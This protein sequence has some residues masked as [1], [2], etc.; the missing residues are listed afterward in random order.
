MKLSPEILLQGYFLLPLGTAALLLLVP[1]RREALISGFAFWSMALHLAAALG[2]IGWWLWH[3]MPTYNLAEVVI[4]AK[5]GYEFLIDLHFD[6]ITAVFLVVG[7]LLTFL[8]GTYSRYYMHREAG[9]RRFFSTILFFFSGYCIVIFSGN[10]ETL[11]IGWEVLGVASFLLIAFYRHRYL[12][13][14]HAVKIFSIYRVGD[15]GLIL[16][17]WATHHLFHG[18]LTFVQLPAA[19]TRTPEL[20]APSGLGLAI[21]LMFLVTAAGKSAQLPFSSWLPRAMEG[22]TPSSAIFYGSLSVHMGV[23]LLLRTYPYWESQ[24]WVRV[25]M[26]VLGLATAFI[27]T[28]IGRV[29]AAAKAQI[30]YASIAQIGVMFIEVAFGWHGLALLHFAG[31]AF[32]RTYQLLISPSVVA[33]LL[34]EQFYHY[35]RVPKIIERHYPRRLAMTLYILCV[36]EWNLDELLYHYVWSPL[37]WIGGLLAFLSPRR[38]LVL[39]GPL[40]V[41]GLGLLFIQGRLPQGAMAALPIACAAIGLALVLKS[42]TKRVHTRVAFL[43]VVVNHLWVGLA[44]SFN[45]QFATPELLYYL[46]GALGAGVIGLAALTWLKRAEPGVSLG[47]F[48]GHIHGHPALGLVFF[49]ACLG[50][51]GFPISTTFIGEDLVFSHIHADQVLLSTLVALSYLVD[52]L[53]LIRIY[54]RVFLGPDRT[55]GDAAMLRSA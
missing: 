1:A 44:I 12:P 15:I 2:L 19:V 16:A 14:K 33:Y 13:A 45:E 42:F 53:A 21:G 22:P 27:A 50:V 41:L 49:L 47:R 46:G 8:I 39:F 6:R 40:Y 9:Y 37:K 24:L 54:A 26:G 51:S 20:L 3:G 23:F 55:D 35:V 34:R 25:A 29:Q 52:G 17:M 18:N 4:Y 48:G 5:D 10:L 28:G 30:A 32:L 43:L 38:I 11:T 36:K 31:N 7:S